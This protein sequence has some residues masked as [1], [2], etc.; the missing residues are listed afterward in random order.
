MN[1][2]ISGHK[3]AVT[4]GMRGHLRDKLARYEKYTSRLVEAHVILK[5]EKYFYE[6]EITL[7]ARNFKAF[8]DGKS[9]EHIFAAM[10]QAAVRVEKQLKKYREKLKSHRIKHAPKDISEKAGKVRRKT[11]KKDIFSDQE[12]EMIPT[13]T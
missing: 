8:G 11:E 3:I 1:I 13:G 5:K 2:R 6:A 7:L 12:P 4:E 10:D 9:K